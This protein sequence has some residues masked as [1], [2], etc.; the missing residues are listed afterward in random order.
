LQPEE[1]TWHFI[2]PQSVRAQDPDNI[3]QSLPVTFSRAGTVTTTSFGP[4]ADA[5]AYIYT[6]SDDVLL[7]GEADISRNT[8]SVRNNDLQFNL[9]STCTEGPVVVSTDPAVVIEPSRPG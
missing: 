4:P 1:V 8:A 3:F 6:P 7:S 2:L 9:G 5:H